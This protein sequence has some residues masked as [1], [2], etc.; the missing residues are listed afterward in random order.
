M[1]ILDQCSPGAVSGVSRH[2]W[3]IVVSTHLH[4]LA[5]I[6]WWWWFVFLFLQSRDIESEVMNNKFIR[7][8]QNILDN[9]DKKESFL[10]VRPGPLLS[11][12]HPFSLVAASRD[13]RALSA[14]R[15]SCRVRLW[16][17]CR[18]AELSLGV[19]NASG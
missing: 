1:N 6:M 5:L 4:Q 2:Y 11:F 3:F 9:P 15:P 8:I 14:E 18:P 13:A 17:R 7:M 16:I 12:V 19:P 10:Q